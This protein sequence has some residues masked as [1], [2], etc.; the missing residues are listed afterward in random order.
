MKKHMTFNNYVIV[1][2]VLLFIYMV[3]AQFNDNL[4]ETFKWV[5]WLLAGITL[6]VSTKNKTML[7]IGIGGVLSAIVVTMNM[8]Y[9]AY[10]NPDLALNV[11]KLNLVSILVVLI[12]SITAYMK[13]GLHSTLGHPFVVVAFILAAVVINNLEFFFVIQ[14]GNSNVPIFIPQLWEYSLPFV[15]AIMVFMYMVYLFT[16]NVMLHIRKRQ[17]DFSR[18]VM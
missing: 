12:G 10:N 6:V 11:Y 13:G 16:L 4:F 17:K 2:S 9:L 7:L 14:H 8:E 18:T 15:K 3:I 5:L 1:G